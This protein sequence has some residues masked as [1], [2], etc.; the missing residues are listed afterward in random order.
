MASPC[1]VISTFLKSQ[2]KVCC[3]RKR[4]LPIMQVPKSGMTPLTTVRV[5]SGVWAASSTKH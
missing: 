5:I 2:K 4:G 1:S 3:I